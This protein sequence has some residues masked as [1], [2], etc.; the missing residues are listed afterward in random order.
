MNNV[1]E[2]LIFRK[3]VRKRASIVFKFRSILGHV[4]V[5]EVGIWKKGARH[6]MGSCGWCGMGLGVLGVNF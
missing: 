5:G 4:S 6:M 1:K 3:D 2:D